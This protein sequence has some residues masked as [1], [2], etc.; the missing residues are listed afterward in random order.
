M[1]KVIH[2][3]ACS[4][5]QSINTCAKFSPRSPNYGSLNA[6]VSW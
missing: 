1:P 5:I 2:E 3:M 6:Q 4:S